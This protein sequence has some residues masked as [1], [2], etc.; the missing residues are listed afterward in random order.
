MTW[1]MFYT[2]WQVTGIQVVH[3]KRFVKGKE[4]ITTAPF[5]KKTL[6]NND[7]PWG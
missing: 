2:R 4:G 3:I 7:I 5:D 1:M 6:V